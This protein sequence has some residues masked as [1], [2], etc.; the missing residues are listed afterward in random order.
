MLDQSRSGTQT[1]AIQEKA[2]DIS[3]KE[4]Q[5]EDKE[6]RK[7]QSN[8]STLKRGLTT[9]S[10]EGPSSLAIVD[11]IF[12]DKIE[13]NSDLSGTFAPKSMESTIIGRNVP[14]E[15]PKKNPRTSN[16]KKLSAILDQKQKHKIEFDCEKIKQNH[17]TH[18][19][20]GN[21][22]CLQFL[23]EDKKPNTDPS[24]KES[25]NAASIWVAKFSPDNKFLA[26][27]GSNGKLRIY[28]VT[29]H[30]E[31]IKKSRDGAP[32][33]NILNPESI[34]LEGHK[35][36]I[37]DISWYKDSRLI[38]TS[39]MDRSVILW[40]VVSRRILQSFEHPDI[41][42]CVSFSPLVDGFYASGCFDKIIRVWD[43][44]AIK[45]KDWIQTTDI[46]T[47]L[48]FSPDK[49]YLL[50]GFVKGAV[51]IYK[52]EKVITENV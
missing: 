21:V 34:E 38:L 4:Y 23:D 33:F 1:Y 51:K 16:P 9:E 17:M 6:N 50:V 7:K 48:T 37:T 32:D 14:E 26:T 13:H 42:S 36:D 43:M 18:S 31:S 46:I 45:V 28:S 2:T 27:G 40:D 12:S 25:K 19:N 35:N 39:S 52:T 5:I 10:N 47:A 20:F 22:I 29:I 24:P 8:F 49:N 41:V 44:N 3:M 30:G 11:N 15:N